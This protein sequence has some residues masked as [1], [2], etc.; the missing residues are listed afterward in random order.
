MDIAAQG[1]II[2]PTLNLPI[3]NKQGDQFDASLYDRLFLLNAGGAVERDFFAIGL[4]EADPISGVLKTLADTNLRQGKIEEGTSFAGFNLK[5][6]QEPDSNKSEAQWLDFVLW[7]RQTVLAIDLP[8]KKDYGTW[9]FS[10]I[11]GIPNMALLVPA[12]AGSNVAF[13]SV[14]AYKSLKEFNLYIPFPRLMDFRITMRQFLAPA[15]T[16]DGDGV[17]ASIIGVKNSA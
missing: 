16:L 15:A 17:C 14:G 4:G 9:K 10:E 12:A 7:A 2:P 5:I 1:P 11:L 3:F 6:W 13:T 8:T